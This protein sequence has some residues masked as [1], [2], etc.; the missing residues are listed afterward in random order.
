MSTRTK[1]VIADARALADPER[2]AG[3][4]RFFKTGP[5]EYGEGDAFLGLTMP[6]VRA[7]LKAHPALTLDDCVELLASKWHE[8]RTL[9]ALG[10][11]RLAKKGDAATRLDVRRAY[12]AHSD[13]INN[14]D[15]VDVSAPEA[16]G[17]SVLERGDLATLEQLAR[18]KSLWERRIAIVATFAH[19]RAGDAAPTLRIAA[20]LLDDPHDLIHKAT[21]WLL[22]EAGKR[23]AAAL[24]AFL[25]RHAATMPRTALRYAIERLPPAVRKEW[26]AR[27]SSSPPG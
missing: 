2:A 1:A 13:R 6:Q 4:A 8:V 21:G 10:M 16:V 22:R 14:W 17:L 9:G 27:K 26:L 24:D 5:G 19:L 11:A 23:D 15:L 25:E 12:L 20:L 7:T 3:V 18:S